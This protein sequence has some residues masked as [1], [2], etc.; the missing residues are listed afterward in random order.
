MR[1]V[2][3]RWFLWNGLWIVIAVLIHQ[4]G[5]Q[6]CLSAWLS[7]QLW[8]P[9]WHFH[10]KLQFSSPDKSHDCLASCFSANLP[11]AGMI[12]WQPQEN[13]SCIWVLQ[14]RE[15]KV[16][17]EKVV[18][19][20]IPENQKQWNGIDSQLTSCL[21]RREPYIQYP[22]SL[23]LSRISDAS[24]AQKREKPSNL[25]AS[26]PANQEHQD[27][28]H[29]AVAI[30]EAW[31]NVLWRKDETKQPKG[32][33][34]GIH[35]PLP[36]P[37]GKAFYV[38]SS[39]AQHQWLLPYYQM[40]FVLGIVILCADLWRRLHQARA[41]AFLPPKI[42]PAPHQETLETL[43]AFRQ[44]VSGLSHELQ[45]PLQCVI[46]MARLSR[47]K[48][49]MLL[50][51]PPAQPSD[52]W[53]KQAEQ[54]SAIS[55]DLNLIDQHGQR[56]SQTVEA[57]ALHARGE[58]L[59]L[60][61][62]DLSALIRTYAQLAYYS[63]LASHPGFPHPMPTMQLHP[64][65][66]V[67][68][69]SSDIGRVFFNIITNALQAIW[70]RFGMQLGGRIRIVTRLEA[71]Q[72]VISITDNGDGIRAAHLE[73]IFEPLFSIQP[74]GSGLGVGLS[75]SR[76]I[77]ARYEAT[78]TCKS[79]EEKGSTFTILFPLETSELSSVME[80]LT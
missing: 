47:E 64:L 55:H 72:I 15:Q 56:A 17:L 14:R 37:Y 70:R 53:L 30:C 77:L 4:N 11:Q 79:Q 63:F 54:W 57:L 27:A 28:I 44:F 19:S 2:L 42:K 62:L 33:P 78:L 65:P 13:A 26:M 31:L 24:G 10:K 32:I 6:P 20:A 23:E 60:E 29:Q 45:N 3:W 51:K 22:F 76:S 41:L 80:E 1:T 69:A 12:V 61:P 18:S 40:G 58:S 46:H 8:E 71:H 43:P 9:A 59:P 21:E 35:Y 39:E 73:R 7:D 49:Q 66:L 52:L 74:P 75:V 68:A 5:L 38:L 34:K 16:I 67:Q 48:V 36:T 50:E 25:S